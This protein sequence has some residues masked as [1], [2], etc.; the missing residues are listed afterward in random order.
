MGL[1]LCF[2]GPGPSRWKRKS[3]RVS[4]HHG[5]NAYWSPYAP[6]GSSSVPTSP[7]SLLCPGHS[8]VVQRLRQREEGNM[9]LPGLE[10]RGPTWQVGGVGWAARWTDF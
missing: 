3:F 9:S 7:V 5:T 6:G 2:R 8:G 1:S 10:G 4:A